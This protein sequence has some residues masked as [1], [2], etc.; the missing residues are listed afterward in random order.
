MADYTFDY[1]TK[2]LTTAKKEHKCYEC[3]NKIYLKD[4]YYRIFGVGGGEPPCF[5]KVC[6][7]CEDLREQFNV[8]RH[9]DDLI[10]YGCLKEVIESYEYWVDQKDN[11]NEKT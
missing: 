8:G 2:K 6:K 7:N 9:I 4:Q 11:K 10:G 3:G 5:L 1:F